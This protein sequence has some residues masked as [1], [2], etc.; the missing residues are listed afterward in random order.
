MNLH[1]FWDF[2]QLKKKMVEEFSLI[3]LLWWKVTKI[4]KE[5][6][7]R[8]LFELC[9]KFSILARENG[10]VIH[11]W[12]LGGI[13][14]YPIIESGGKKWEIW[15]NDFMLIGEYFHTVDEK[16]RVSLPAKFRKI[17]GKSV[18]ITP[19]LDKCLFVFNQSEWQKVARKLSGG[20]G[21]SFLS[22]D[23]RA[24]NRIM[25]GQAAN[26]EVDRVG[27]VL[28]P[29]VLKNKAR[30]TERAVMVGVE[31]RVEIWNESA[32]QAEK[33]RTEKEAEAIAEKLSNG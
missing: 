13:G 24:F 5:L 2:P 19:G 31:D 14:A 18:V 33:N 17:M 15:G 7:R 29:E 11:S 8:R 32:W 1:K 9:I 16:N 10:L 30:I 6:I 23:Q 25:F 27:R 26:A 12:G 20:E 4:H 3:P 22:S 21:L 28:I